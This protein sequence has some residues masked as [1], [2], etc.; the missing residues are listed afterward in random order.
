VPNRRRRARVRR[1]RRRRRRRRGEARPGGEA[2]GLRH[3]ARR[4]RWRRLALHHRDATAVAAAAAA[5]AAAA[6]AA[7]AREHERARGHAEGGERIG[8]ASGAIPARRRGGPA[9][10]GEK[11]GEKQQETPPRAPFE[12]ASGRG[13]H[14]TPPSQSLLP[15]EP[16]ARSPAEKGVSERGS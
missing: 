1:G 13:A 7:A 15:V 5:C 11:G 10:P 16:P 14:P 4:R 3:A 9:L 6:R 8:S 2:R 12:P